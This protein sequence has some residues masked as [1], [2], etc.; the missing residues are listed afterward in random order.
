MLILIMFETV[1]GYLR[2]VLTQVVTTRIDGRMNLYIVEKLLKLPME[3]FERTPTGRIFTNSSQVW[4]IL[5]F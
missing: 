1:L 5:T 2:R 3:Y 4:L